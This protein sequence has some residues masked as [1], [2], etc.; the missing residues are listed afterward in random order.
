MIELIGA[1]LEFL[2]LPIVRFFCWLAG[3]LVGNQGNEHRGSDED[4]LSR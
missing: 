1:L 4:P 3:R 2:F